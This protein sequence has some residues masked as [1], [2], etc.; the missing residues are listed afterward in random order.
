MVAKGD[1][2][3]VG[4]ELVV[5]THNGRVHPNAFDGEGI[6]NKFHFN[7]D[8]A[9]DDDDDMCCRKAVD[10]FGVEEACEVAMESFITADQFV[11]E[12]EARLESALF[13]PEYGSERAREEDAFDGGKCN[14]TD[15][16]T[17]IGGVVPFE[18]LV[19]FALDA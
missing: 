15:G 4:P 7:V 10:R 9:A 2:E 5:V 14:H 12:A 6:N 13:E 18:S 11:A 19:G 8:R 17:G 1:Q 3:L 16:E